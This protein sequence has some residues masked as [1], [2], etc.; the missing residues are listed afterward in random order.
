[1]AP[2]GTFTSCNSPG[3]VEQV[4]AVVRLRRIAPG[5]TGWLRAD[6]VPVEVRSTRGGTMD[7]KTTGPAAPADD[8]PGRNAAEPKAPGAD[9]R[10]GKHRRPRRRFWRFGWPVAGGRR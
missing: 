3:R 10:R 1:M 5:R 6:A 2:A 4:I 8:T 7:D 9:A